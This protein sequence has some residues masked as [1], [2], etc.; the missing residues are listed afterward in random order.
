[1]K[2]SLP[3]KTHLIAFAAAAVCLPLATA[4]AAAAQQAELR[5]ND[6]NLAVPAGQATLEGRIKVAARSVCAETEMAGAR[7]VD[8]ACTRQVRSQI[9]SQIAER[10]NR[11]GKGS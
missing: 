5:Y 4:P 7:F 1:M 9:M 10:Q 11:V 3:K 8:T 6:L 2:I